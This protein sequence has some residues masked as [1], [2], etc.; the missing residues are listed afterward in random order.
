MAGT[1]PVAAPGVGQDQKFVCVVV[2]AL[3]ISPPPLLEGIHGKPGGIRRDPHMNKS[4]ISTHI[5]YSI[6]GGLAQRILG[7]IVC[8]DFHRFSNP[9]P[10]RV[11]KI[12]D[13]FFVFRIHADDGQAAPKEAILLLLNITE[14]SVTVRM[15][16]TREAFPIRLQ[17]QSRLFNNRIT[18]TWETSWPRVAIAAAN[19][20]LV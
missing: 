4:M 13:E 10:A 12:A 15:G 19:L 8:I 3:S 20:R 9:C 11:L 14:L 7:K 18:V 1:I 6:R 5:V 17:A 2:M 16:R